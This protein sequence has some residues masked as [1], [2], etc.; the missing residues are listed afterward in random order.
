LTLAAWRGRHHATTGRE[1]ISALRT[2]YA[3]AAYERRVVRGMYATVAAGEDDARTL[4]RLAGR[5]SVHTI[6][7][8]VVVPAEAGGSE[9]ALPTVAFTGVLDYPP[10]VDA[11]CH[12]AHAVWPGIRAAVPAARFVI[13]GRHPLHRV[14][15]LAGEPGIEVRAD[16]P[17]MADVLREAWVA[18]APMICGSGIKNKVLEAWAVGRPVAMTTLATNGLALT[19]AA[20]ELVADDSATLG[21]VIIDLLR[22]PERRRQLGSHLRD[23]VQGRHRWRSAAEHLSALLRGA[24]AARFPLGT[25]QPQDAARASL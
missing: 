16:V 14:L 17:S 13:A 24:R 20:Q 1:W 19:P 23:H 5:R 7:N 2:V 21:R 22:H 6:P 18:V 25:V 12:F 4:R 3:C 10:N 15:A 8:G 9:G 11:A